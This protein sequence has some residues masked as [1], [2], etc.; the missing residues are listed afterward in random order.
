[1]W[2]PRFASG[3]KGGDRNWAGEGAG[4][5]AGGP[6]TPRAFGRPAAAGAPRGVWPVWISIVVIQ[7]GH[8][9]PAGPHRHIPVR[10]AS[11]PCRTSTPA[12]TLGYPTPRATPWS[13]K[14]TSRTS[15]P[16]G[17]TAVDVQGLAGD[18]AG[19]FEIEDPV[20]DVADLADPPDGVKTRQA[21]V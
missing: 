21:L 19:L 12:V 4:G 3:V 9:R 16:G 14:R 20:G 13:P 8:T 5:A 6:A 17:L 10:N 1:V 15:V 2:G 11:H 18:K 7:T